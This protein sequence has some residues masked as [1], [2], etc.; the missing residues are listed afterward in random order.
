MAIPGGGGVG[1]SGEVDLLVGGEE[2]G[3]EAGEEREI[4]GL[5]LNA[6]RGGLGCE[7]LGYGERGEGAEVE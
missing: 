1:D 2:R 6:Q 4:G 7:V 3:E 5:K